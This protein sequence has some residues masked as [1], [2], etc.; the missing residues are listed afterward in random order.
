MGQAADP[1]PRFGIHNIGVMVRQ[2]IGADTA[3]E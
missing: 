3:I 2:A 1:D